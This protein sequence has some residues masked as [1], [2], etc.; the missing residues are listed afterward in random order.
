MSGELGNGNTV[1]IPGKIY[2]RAGLG[3]QIASS[4]KVEPG[5]RS[6]GHR[7]AAWGTS[8]IDVTTNPAS[9][10]LNFA[11]D[12]KGIEFSDMSEAI[13]IGALTFSGNQSPTQYGFSVGTMTMALDEM[14]VA[15]GGIQAGGI[16]AMN[17][18]GNTTLDGDRVG[19]RTTF[20]METTTLPQIGDVSVTGDMSVVGA[21]AEAL[22]G[23]TRAMKALQPNPDPMQTFPSLEGDLKRL[24]ASG[25][26]MR[27]D[28][29]DVALP[30]GTVAMTMNLKVAEKDLDTFEWTSL[31]LSTEGAATLSIPEALVDMALT[32][33]PQAGAMVAMGLLVKSGDA[34][35]MDARLEK[36]LLTINGAPIPIPM[37]A[38]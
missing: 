35:E 17:V 2:S 38:F 32:M 1:E 24:L 8:S 34:Y 14:S 7:K 9:G 12:I 31:L 19:G 26:E 6:D 4:Y 29:L 27:F 22:G 21:D 20:N 37:G 36:G 16:K 11:G 3:G 28:Q 23:L 18:E 13:G 15:T 33:N 25:L 5:S 10:D 30:T